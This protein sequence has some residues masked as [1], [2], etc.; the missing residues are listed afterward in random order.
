MVSQREEQMREKDIRLNVTGLEVI[1]EFPGVG[2]LNSRLS[3]TLALLKFARNDLFDDMSSTLR[4]FLDGLANPALLEFARF[5]DILDDLDKP[6]ALLEFARFD[7]ILDDLDKPALLEFARFDDFLDDMDNPAPLEFARFDDFLD[8][9]DKPALLEFACKE[10]AV[11]FANE[12]VGDLKVTDLIGLAV[13]ERQYP[14]NVYTRETYLT[15]PVQPEIGL[16]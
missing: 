4:H 8:D 16:H 3:S 2:D 9:M 14:A 13:V 15:Q 7:D 1:I 12:I 10:L 11:I 6:A 5:D